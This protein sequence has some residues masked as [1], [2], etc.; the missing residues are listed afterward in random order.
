MVLCTHI[1]SFS[2]PM[3][4]AVVMAVVAD[5]AKVLDEGVVEI[6]DKDTI[7]GKTTTLCYLLFFVASNQSLV[8]N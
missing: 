7:K 3:Q 4:V 8:K 6:G 1:I 2:K 5:V